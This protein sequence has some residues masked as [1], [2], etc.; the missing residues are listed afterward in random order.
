MQI[1]PQGASSI[2]TQTVKTEKTGN[3]KLC[4]ACVESSLSLKGVNIGVISLEHSLAVFANP[5]YTW[6]N[7]TDVVVS[8]RVSQH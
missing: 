4:C 3:T 8:E 2:P 5:K 7:L 6:I 1:K